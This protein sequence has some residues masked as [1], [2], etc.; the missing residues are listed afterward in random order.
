MFLDKISELKNLPTSVREMMLTLMQVKQFK[1]GECVHE[2]GVPS[3]MAVVYVGSVEYTGPKGVVTCE[4]NDVL[5]KQA[6][7]SKN[8]PRVT[9]T[10]STV[11]LT[12]SQKA[13]NNIIR[14]LKKDI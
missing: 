1:K 14:Q 10:D 4:K 12:L 2:D 7:R 11:L 8:H 6:F 9:S 13:Y 3:F 5:M